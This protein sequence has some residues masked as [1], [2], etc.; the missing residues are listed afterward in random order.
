MAASDDVGS[1]QSMESI[2]TAMVNV[3]GERRAMTSFISSVW[4]RRPSNAP[5]VDSLTWALGDRYVGWHLS[6]SS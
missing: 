6:I 5:G 4:I 1:N 2:T 3:P